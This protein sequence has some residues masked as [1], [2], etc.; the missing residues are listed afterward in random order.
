MQLSVIICAHNSR[1]DFLRRTLDGIKAQTL[2]MEQWE[3]MLIDNASKEPMAPVW[4]LSWHPHARHIREEELGI[5]NARLRAIKESQGQLLVFV[6]D[7]NVL[8]SDYLAVM[9]NKITDYPRIGCFGAGVLEPEF[10]QE[11]APEVRPHTGCL[12][13]RTVT[14]PQ[15]SNSM[16]DLIIPWGA[17]MGV[18]R[19][20]AEKYAAEVRNSPIRK[21]LGRTGSNLSSC[22]DD[23]F[24]WVACE[25]GLGKGLFPALQVTHLIGRKRVEKKYLLSIAEGNGFSQVLIAYIHLR[26]LVSPPQPSTFADVLG[27]LFRAKPFAAIRHANSWWNNFHMPA[28][29]KEFEDAWRAGARRGQKVL[30]EMKRAKSSME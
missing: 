3:L 7:D 30:A 6:D 13:L 1:P 21:L 8:K 23:E 26:P 12:A 19:V 25:L 27:S 14:T 11:P 4:D 17:G 10:E 29:E 15:W 20:V 5:V 22:E 18:R 2:P 24:S 9:A 16:N 28:L